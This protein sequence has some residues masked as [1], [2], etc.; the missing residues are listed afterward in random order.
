MSSN[1][2]G[3]N[4]IVIL[5]LM[6]IYSII[7]SSDC[8][9]VSTSPPSEDRT[10]LTPVWI[11]HAWIPNF[12]KWFWKNKTRRNMTCAMIH[13][14]NQDTLFKSKQQVISKLFSSFRIDY[15][16]IPYF[17][18]SEISKLS[19]IITNTILLQTHS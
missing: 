17:F 14:A 18:F 15:R 1:P 9:G 11:C 7:N 4:L 6:R 10:P 12:K 8:Y 5:S 19:A 3:V 2:L 13:P 16:S